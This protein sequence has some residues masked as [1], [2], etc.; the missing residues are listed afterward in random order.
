MVQAVHENRDPMIVLDSARHAVEIINAIF[1]SGRT[2][3][4]V[5]IG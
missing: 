4:E 1:E 5:R 2:G 3:K